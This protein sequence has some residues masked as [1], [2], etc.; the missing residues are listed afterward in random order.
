MNRLSQFA[1]PA[2][3]AGRVA[4]GAFLALVGLMILAVMEV[5]AAIYAFDTSPQ[6]NMVAVPWGEAPRD[7]LVYAALSVLFGLAGYFGK[8]AGSIRADDERPHVRAGA[9][10]AS[11]FALACMLVPTGNFA[12]SIAYKDDLRAYEVNRPSPANP[13]GSMAWR[14]AQ[15]V[16]ATGEPD[17]PAVQRAQRVL[18]PPAKGEPGAHHWAMAIALAVMAMACGSAFRVPL[19]ITEAERNAMVEREKRQERNRR[20]RE[21]RKLNKRRTIPLS[22]KTA[23]N[24]IKAWPFAVKAK[25]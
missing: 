25:A 17:D 13:E 8:I 1:G 7:A 14:H 3:V 6:S 9:W 19:P 4:L 10:K 18:N 12:H 24:V 16:V 21:R 15:E 22:D 23:D 2:N 11:C 20:R 5:S